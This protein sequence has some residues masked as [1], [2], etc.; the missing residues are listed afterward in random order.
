MESNETLRPDEAVEQ[1]EKAPVT[2][3]DV[4]FRSGSKNYF[5][6]PGALTVRTGDDVVIETARGAEFG[7]CV[8]G[9]HTVNADEVV[10][11]LRPVLRL[12]TAHRFFDNISRTFNF[13]IKSALL[14]FIQNGYLPDEDCFLQLDERN[15]RVENKS[16]L[17]NYLN[18]E[19]SLSGQVAGNFSVSYF[20]SACNKFVQIADVFSN[21]FYSHLQTGHYTDELEL[22]KELGIL[23]GVYELT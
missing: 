19:L 7:R 9:N 5:F 8:R 3:C 6:D 13:S 15:E 23:K 21:L 22:M 11:P 14:Y 12:A 1:P 18:T 16:F 20:D 4:Q 10:A 2:V 17:E